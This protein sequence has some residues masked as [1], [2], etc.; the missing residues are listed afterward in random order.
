M[1]V[2]HAN[3]LSENVGRYKRFPAFL[4]SHLPTRQNRV[5][6]RHHREEGLDWKKILHYTNSWTHA[7]LMPLPLTFLPHEKRKPA[8]S[9]K[10]SI[11]KDTCC[12]GKCLCKK[13]SV[14]IRCYII[15]TNGKLSLS[16]NPIIILG[17][18][19]CIVTARHIL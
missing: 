2:P 19:F 3:I 18:S 15:P 5:K 13:Y 1:A 8:G 12:Y 6:I 7:S 16:D 4:F 11:K 9:L 14:F 10:K 17:F